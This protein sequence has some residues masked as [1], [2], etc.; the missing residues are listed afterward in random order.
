M[1]PQACPDRRG[2]DGGAGGRAPAQDTGGTPGQGHGFGLDPDELP[3]G[4]VVADH[5]GHVV[6]FN[7]AAS[8]I[9]AITAGQALGARIERALPLEDLEGRRW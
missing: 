5:T 4:L 9:T 7:R 8:R 3:D 2:P 1:P 6:C